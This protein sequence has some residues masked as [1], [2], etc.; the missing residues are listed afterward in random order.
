MTIAVCASAKPI[1]IFATIPPTNP[2][3][4]CRWICASLVSL[5]VV[6]LLAETCWQQ[7]TQH[8]QHGQSLTNTQ[9]WFFKKETT[10][11]FPQGP[12]AALWPDEAQQYYAKL[13]GILSRY[14]P[15]EM[16]PKHAP[17]AQLS[18]KQRYLRTHLPRFAHT[19]LRAQPHIKP[20]SSVVALGEKGH[21]P[22]LLHA[23]FQPSLLKVTTMEY[24][25]ELVLN[26]TLTNS[27]V[28]I[29]QLQHNAEMEPLAFQ[30]GSIDAVFFLEV[31]EHLQKDP[32]FAIL[33]MHRVLKPNGTLF[34][35]TPNLG[36][37]SALA[38]LHNG[39]GPYAYS[40]YLSNEDGTGSITH[41]R[42]YTWRELER[43]L[44]VAGFAPTLASFSPYPGDKEFW[45]FAAQQPKQ[46]YQQLLAALP[47]QHQ[48]L[49]KLG[50]T[51]FLIARKVR[52]PFERRPWQLYAYATQFEFAGYP[53]CRHKQHQ[54]LC[55]PVV[56]AE[57]GSEAGGSSIRSVRN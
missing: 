1:Y 38:R 16:P 27:S 56:G 33:E 9:L 55:K 17:P 28:S 54:R 7:Q 13:E 57:V 6:L 42:E 45:D 4:K 18:N 36:G 32:F 46:Q 8:Q 29:Q 11:T 37:F 47:Q 3:R 44:E 15:A 39:W 30:T 51:A 20:G 34:L 24:P 5:L 52:K 48:T 49:D 35:S 53:V 10:H 43:F 26:D 2:S 40:K 22:A 25:G 19:M 21:V 14:F 23:L 12:D 31:L 41:V 50:S